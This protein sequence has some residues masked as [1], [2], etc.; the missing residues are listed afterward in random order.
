MN[1]KAY[2][3]LGS[4]IGT[5]EMYLKEAIS[6]LNISDKIKLTNYS[7]IYETDP[8]GYEDQQ[9]FLNMVVEIET[10]YSANELLDQ[11]LSIEHKL[12]RKRI[13]HW[14]P[15][16]IDLDILL[17]NQENIDTEQLVIPHPRMSERA[18]VLIPLAEINP[19][20]KIPSQERSITQLID[21]IFN[22]GVR[23]WKVK[24][25]VD[26]YELFES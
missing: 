14:G 19:L 13:I 18:F 16:T 6:E 2:L 12:G 8:V 15:R 23:L 22:K 11:C 7:S 1:N 5:R 20:L 25:G 24:S 26:V 3:S 10:D 9:C 21:N 17:Y 4:N